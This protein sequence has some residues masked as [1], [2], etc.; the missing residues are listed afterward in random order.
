MS[1]RIKN[2]FHPAD[3][4]AGFVESDVGFG[5]VITEISRP[6]RPG[7]NS[8][9]SRLLRADSLLTVTG[10]DAYQKPLD[11]VLEDIHQ[12]ILY[13]SRS[14]YPEVGRAPVGHW[15]EPVI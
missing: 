2:R 12:P 8:H 7:G 4:S 1:E 6:G 10:N 5:F 15:G 14:S 3:P 13:Y 11:M 9:M